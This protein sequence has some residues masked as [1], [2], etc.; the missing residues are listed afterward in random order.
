ML[1]IVP[2]C[3]PERKTNDA[4]LKKWQKAEVQAQFWTPIFFS[5]V[6]PPLVSIVP[7]YHPIQ[8]KRKLRRQT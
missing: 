7:C 4:N 3:N 5:L 6:L 2:S 8:F 1:D